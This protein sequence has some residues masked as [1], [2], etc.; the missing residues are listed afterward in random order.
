MYGFDNMSTK[1]DAVNKAIVDIQ[2][3]REAIDHIA[4]VEDK[5]LLSNFSI[6]QE[7]TSNME[8]DMF[9]VPSNTEEDTFVQELV[10]SRTEEDTFVVPSNTEEDTF[11]QE[12]V[13]SSTEEVT[14][15]VPSNTEEDT[16]LQELVPSSTEEDT[17]VVL[18][19]EEDTFVVPSNT[20]EDTFVVPSNTE[21]DTFVQELVPSSTEEDTFVV[22]NTEEDTFV[23]ELVPS[24]TEDD[25][26]VVL[27][28]EEDTFVVPSNTEEDTFVVP[29]NTEEVSFVQELVPSSTEDNTFVVLN[30]EEDTFVQEL[31]PSSTEDDTF[32]VP[33][34]TE[35][36]TFVVPSNTEEVSFVVR[37]N[38]EEDTFVVPSNTE[39][40]TFVQELVPSVVLDKQISKQRM[41]IKRRAQREKLKMVAKQNFLRRNQSKIISKIEKMYPNIGNVI[42]DFVQQGNV[43][44]DAWR[45]TGVLTFDG[46]IKIPQK[47]TYE[48]IRKHLCE[49]YDRHFSHGSVVQLCIPRNKRH[50]SAKRYRGIAKVTSR[51]ARKGFNI[52][53]NLDSHWSGAFYKGLDGFQ[54]KD[55]RNALV[56]NRNDAAGFQL[57]T[58]T[59]SKQYSA[60]KVSCQDV[61]TT[62]TDYVNKY[63]SVLQTTSYNFSKTET[64]PEICVGVVKAPG[65]HQKCL[66]QHYEDQR[67]LSNTDDLKSA[68]LNPFGKNKLIDCIRVDGAVDEGP[69]HLEVQFWW[70]LWHLKNEKMATLI[71]TR[72]SG[73]SY[74]NRVELQNGCLSRCHSNTFIPSTISGSCVDSETGNINKEKLKENLSLAINAYI[75]RVNNSPCGNTTISFIKDPVLSHHK[76]MQ[77]KLITFLKGSGKKRAITSN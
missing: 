49:F 29:S 60:P 9:I 54:F 55:G 30:T 73:S 40:D 1:N 74:L 52:R 57:D 67:M 15:V 14:F 45:R 4:A 35:E 25:T 75:S 16:Y 11:V 3:I 77:G 47:I 33:C 36:D 56:L 21:E 72:C 31:V 71:T 44:A 2:S 38:T 24:S 65:L 39:D 22:L 42:E 26:F 46:N 20:E 58:L 13:P 6:E 23:Q 18:N 70:T 5:V 48:R 66:S 10:P 8:D 50:Q 41:Q 53:Y 12:L 51:R 19:T 59:T 34:N 28:T 17:F 69:S 76:M 61:L 7:S 43:G 68:F 32:V 62:H 27:N 37:S 63:P 64:T